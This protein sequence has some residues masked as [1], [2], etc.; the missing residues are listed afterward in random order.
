MGDTIGSGV[1]A[2]HLLRIAAAKRYDEW[3]VEIPARC[4]YHD[5]RHVLANQFGRGDNQL[6]VLAA[7]AQDQRAFDAQPL[8][9]LVTLPACLVC[10]EGEGGCAWP[11]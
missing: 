6:D 11:A 10:A 3:M 1:Q 5:D 9:K 4:S 8:T 2:G 7:N